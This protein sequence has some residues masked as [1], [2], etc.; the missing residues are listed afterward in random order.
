MTSKR[1]SPRQCART[2]LL[3]L[4][5]TL[6]PLAAHAEPSPREKAAAEALFQQATALIEQEK[7]A[8]ACTKFE[9][10][11]ELDPA[12]GTML[13]LADCYDRVGRTASAWALF[14]EAVAVASASDQP[15]REQI[16]AQRARDLEGRLA[17][18]SLAVTT[19]ARVPGLQVRLNG[20]A[21][22]SASWNAALP[23]DPG[24]QRVEAS[25]P[26]REP[27]AGTVEVPAGP[28][29]RSITVPVLKLRPPEK[30]TA[31][32]VVGTAPPPLPPRSAPGSTQRTLGY[33]TASVGLAGLVA[34]G[35]LA[36]RAYDLNDQSLSQCRANDP[37]ACTPEGKS[38]RDDAK[39]FATTSTIAVAAGGALL[40]TGITL[41]LAAPSS[42]SH[43]SAQRALR[44]HTSPLK[45]GARLT[46]EGDF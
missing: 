1:R 32:A 28:S 39:S 19:E 16:A 18:V 31:A 17:K 3:A 15:E 42:E 46:L 41:V 45:R 2:A 11:Q 30:P 21:I 22:P 40:A 6:L 24:A 8:D 13:R 26:D 36:Y 33:V 9:G 4:A 35:V 44:L 38:L 7:F 43:D 25:A 10:S 20:V 29:E 27:W 14:Q 5:A 37:N 34:G 12:L 23:V